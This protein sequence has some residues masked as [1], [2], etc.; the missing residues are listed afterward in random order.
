MSRRALDTDTR[1]ACPLNSFEIVD[2]PEYIT[3]LLSKFV[4]DGGFVAGGIMRDLMYSSWFDGEITE[5]PSLKTKDIDVFFID[6]ETFLKVNQQYSMDPFYALEHKL[7]NSA[8]WRL[9]SH[10]QKRRAGSSDRYRFFGQ[11]SLINVDML[12][13]DLVSKMYGSVEDILN[14]FDFTASQCAFYKEESTGKYLIKYSE[15]FKK[16]LS[17]KKLSLNKNHG[18]LE[19]SQI[20]IIKRVIQYKDYGFKPEFHEKLDILKTFVNNYK[21]IEVLLNKHSTTIDKMLYE[22]NNLFDRLVESV[23]EERE[24]DKKTPSFHQVHYLN[25]VAVNFF[26]ELLE[27]RNDKE[28]QLVEQYLINAY[29]NPELFLYEDLNY[30]QRKTILLL[31]EELKNKSITVDEM[32]SVFE[33]CYYYNLTFKNSQDTYPYS[34]DHKLL[35]KITCRKCHTSISFCQGYHITH[36]SIGKYYT[37]LIPESDSSPFRR[38]I[39]KSFNLNYEFEFVYKTLMMGFDEETGNLNSMWLR[40]TINFWLN[41]RKEIIV[42]ELSLRQWHSV[43]ENNFFNPNMPFNI[44]FNLAKSY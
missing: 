3:Q 34:K 44:F 41:F 7:H 23:E 15:N 42:A 2:S 11:R 43:L 25:R 38:N 5:E 37:D 30:F 36:K 21:E 12:S 32:R 1:K 14:S 27:E 39:H 9:D 40:D 20:N 8:C 29:I 19:K 18:I 33:F 35:P 28:K 16:D 17:A 10:R 4:D 22:D 13:I 26:Y 24:D 31:G 6:E